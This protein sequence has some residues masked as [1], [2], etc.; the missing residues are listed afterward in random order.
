MN[1]NFITTIS[2]KE[3]SLNDLKNMVEKT[4]EVVNSFEMVD[5]E[6]SKFA[7][8]IASARKV[9]KGIDT[10]RKEFK[11]YHMAKIDDDLDALKEFENSLHKVIEDKADEKRA[12]DE[13]MLNQRV[14]ECTALFDEIIPDYPFDIDFG[15]VLLEDSTITNKS[16]T[17]NKRE[18]KILKVLND[19]NNIYSLVDNKNLIVK[20]NFDVERYQRR[21]AEAQEVIKEMDI[22]VTQPQAVTDDSR[23]PIL[24][25]KGY[26][27]RLISLN[28]PF[29]E[30]D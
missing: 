13:Q 22:P 3:V 20:C 7:K 8:D 26:L 10:F 18:E 15:I 2:D 1:S 27:K 5:G 19:F 24:I 25:E 12:F 23:V 11:K 17:A 6:E 14:A 30:L 4:K 9:E 16:T 21:V 28:I 29:E